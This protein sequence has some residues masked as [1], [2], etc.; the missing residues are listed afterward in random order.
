MDSIFSFRT[1][2]SITKISCHDVG[3]S[4]FYTDI[5]GLV[6]DGRYTIAGGKPGDTPYVQMIIPG[7]D[8]NIAIGLFQDIDKPFPP[9]DFDHLPPGTVP[10][11]V[12][13]DID[14]ARA[15]L[16]SCGVRVSP[17][18]DEKSDKGYTDRIAFFTDPENNV[19]VI[20]QNTN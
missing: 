20:R 11:F 8:N 10:T 14:A 12:V 17:V 6:I 7:L 5:L 19:L 15:Y 9:V 1:I 3:V 2:G 16:V 18:I 13:P 4:K